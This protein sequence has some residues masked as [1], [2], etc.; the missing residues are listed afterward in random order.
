MGTRKLVRF[1]KSFNLEGKTIEVDFYPV[2]SIEKQLYQVYIPVDGK[3]YRIHMQKD[4]NGSFKIALP[5]QV[6]GPIK[7]LESSFEQAIMES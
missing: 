3:F 7:K 1:K 6:P 4:N 5:D 2:N